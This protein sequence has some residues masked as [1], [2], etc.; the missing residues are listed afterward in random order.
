M[1]RPAAISGRW[2]LVILTASIALWAVMIFGT[3]AHLRQLAG[4][5]D[6][7]DVRPF[8]YSTAQ[9]RALL[10]A[11]GDA[12]RDFYANVQLRIDMIYPATY[13]LSRALVLWWVTA[14]GRLRA[15]PI[16]MILRVL[17]LCPALAAAGFG[18]AENVLIGRMLAVGPTIDSAVIESASQMTLAKSLLSSLNE[19]LV[20]VLAVLAAV[21]WRRW[22]QR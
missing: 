7:F 12:G 3:L 13:A 10:D 18:Y 15:A 17:L 6:P 20:I 21:R 8:G 2:V 22:P 5:I 4:G 9:A 16:P 1:I 11:L 19:T 14:P